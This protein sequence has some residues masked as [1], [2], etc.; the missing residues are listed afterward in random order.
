MTYLTIQEQET[1]AYLAGDITLAYALAQVI[2]N[3]EVLDQLELKL[4]EAKSDSLAEWESNNGPAQDYYDFF[5]ECF[6]FLAGHYP[7]PSVTSEHDRSI[8]FNAISKGE[9]NENS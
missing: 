5:F 7:C 8:I 9:Q 3:E 6:E 1:R 2:D 4:D